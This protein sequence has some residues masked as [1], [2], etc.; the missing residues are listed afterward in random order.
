MEFKDITDK[1][2][3]ERIKEIANKI[4]MN[5]DLKIGFVTDAPRQDETK[6]KRYLEKLKKLLPNL[7]VLYFGPGP[8][9]DI[10]LVKVTLSPGLNPAK[11]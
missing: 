3:D 5:P 10:I 1:S 4:L 6:A 9:R 8:T 2:E 7:T 11:K